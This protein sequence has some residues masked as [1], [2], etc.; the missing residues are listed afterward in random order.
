MA[1]GDCHRDLGDLDAAA[2]D[3]FDGADGGFGG[4]RADDGN[5]ADVEDG[6]EDLAFLHLPRFY[7]ALRKPAFLSHTSIGGLW[8]RPSGKAI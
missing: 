8:R 5:D 3:G 7:R 2:V 4:V 1:P 6:A